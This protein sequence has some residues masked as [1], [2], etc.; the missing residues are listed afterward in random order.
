MMLT[1][2]RV[3][4]QRLPLPLKQELLEADVFH[5]FKLLLLKPRQC[6]LVAAAVLRF[7]LVPG[8]AAV[9][10]L[11]R[12][13]ERVIVQPAGLRGLV[14][15]EFLCWYLS[16][17]GLKPAKGPPEQPRAPDRLRVKIYPLWKVFRGVCEVLCRQQPRCLQLFERN[18]QRIPGKG[19]QRLVG[20]VAVAGRAQRQYL[21][22]A[23]ARFRQPVHP[24]AGLWTLQPLPGA[25]PIASPPRRG[26][27]GP[28]R[29][30][31]RAQARRS[32]AAAPRWNGASALAEL[33]GQRVS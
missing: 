5:P 32:G 19:P 24:G 18:Q 23:L 25:A 22:V 9:R 16:F 3:R 1:P 30:C 8:R 27:V 28:A 13:K 10:F 20:A 6:A 4:P 33:R 21:P 31:R 26:P 29:L 11:E 14:P 12:K 7:P 2:R 17:S 15:R